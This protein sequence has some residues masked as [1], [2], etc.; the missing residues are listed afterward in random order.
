MDDRTHVHVDHFELMRKIGLRKTPVG[1]EPT[2]VYEQDPSRGHGATEEFGHGHRGRFDFG[3]PG[4]IA[5]KMVQKNFRSIF[6][7]RAAREVA[8][9]E[10]R[11]QRTTKLNE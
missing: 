6:H 10:I 3:R 7:R 9:N 5:R 4:Q 8:K 2:V 1:A 11:L